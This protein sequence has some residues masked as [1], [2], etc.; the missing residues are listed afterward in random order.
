MSEA[1]KKSKVL[2][3]FKQA[4]AEGRQPNCPYCSKPLD[5]VRQNTTNVSSWD[6][7]EVEKEYAKHED[8]DASNEPFCQSCGAKDWDFLSDKQDFIT[9]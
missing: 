7:N 1:T 8:G 6:W 4:R 2:E 3:E 5:E 9:Y